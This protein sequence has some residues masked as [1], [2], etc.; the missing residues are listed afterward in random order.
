MVTTTVLKCKSCGIDNELGVRFC[1]KC[2]VALQ[3]PSAPVAAAPLSTP[4][5][6][7]CPPIISYVR[8]G[9]RVI[10]SDDQSVQMVRPKT[11]NET[12]A[13]FIVVATPFAAAFSAILHPLLGLAI[14]VLASV[15]LLI[16]VMVYF[17]ASDSTAYLYFGDDGQVHSIIH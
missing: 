14:S 13:I 3:S 17:G 4:A 16:L 7:L 8:V 5:E 11:F 15:C 2:G 10:W 12:V 1:I 6:L 9:Y